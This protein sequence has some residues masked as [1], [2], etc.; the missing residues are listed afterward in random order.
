MILGPSECQDDT[1]F[2]D[3]LQDAKLPDKERYEDKNTEVIGGILPDEKD[4]QDETN[5]QCQIT[6]QPPLSNLLRPQVLAGDD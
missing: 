6:Q 5:I 4:S 2:L 3:G 1:G